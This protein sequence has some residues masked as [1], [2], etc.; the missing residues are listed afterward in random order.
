MFQWFSAAW[1]CTKESEIVWVQFYAEKF[2]IKVES[3][4]L[5]IQINS[6]KTFNGFTVDEKF[7][8]SGLKREKLTLEKRR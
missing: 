7:L 2:G 4:C 1:Q 3:I 6:T 5:G 8:I